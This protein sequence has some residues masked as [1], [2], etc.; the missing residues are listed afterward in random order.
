MA[1]AGAKNQCFSCGK[2]TRTFNCEGCL[3]NYCP[4]DLIKHLQELNEQFDKIE[5]NHDEFRQIL[6]EQKTNPEKHSLI[7]QINQWEEDSITKIKQ[8]AEE[9]RTELMKYTNK[10]IMEL[11]NQLN[12]L[13]KQ[14]KD[15][16]QDNQFNEIDLKQFQEK[17]NKLKDEL[18]KPSK[19]SIE[20]ETTKFINKI[21]IVSSFET[22]KHYNQFL[23][24][25][26][27]IY[28]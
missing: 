10:Y 11:E 24:F 14:M 7:R 2:E 16:R 6:N 1:T 21:F 4:N 19:I 18:D 20:Q 27:I 13:A 26:A 23:F 9:C 25:N 28:I 8:T 17:L 22:G 12:N 5:T 3:R 15:I